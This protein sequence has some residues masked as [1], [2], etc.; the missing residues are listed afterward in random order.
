MITIFTARWVLPISASPIAQGAVAIQATHIIAVGTR[1]ELCR[2]FPDALLRDLGEA[3]LL[4]GFVN[5]HSH[6]ELTVYRGRLEHAEFQ[7]WISELVRLKQER[8]SIDDLRVSARLG[9]L[10]AIKAG[11]TT[12]ADTMEADA[13]LPALIESGQRGVVFQ[14]CFGPSVAQA[15]DILN[16]LR[17][18]LDAHAARLARAEAGASSRLRI[19]I[20]PHAPYSVSSRL[21]ELA[22]QFAIDHHF[23]LALH[24]AESC[25]EVALLT[26]GRGAFGAFLQRREIEFNAPACSTIKYFAQLGV[27]AA[28][29]LLI[30]CVTVD[31]ADIALLAQHRARV[32][33]CPKSN[34]KL[35]HGVAPFIAMRQAGLRIGLGTDSVGSNNSGD[36]LEEAR[37]GALLQRAVNKDARLC[38]PDEMLR[39]LTIDGARALGWESEIGSLEVGKQADLIAISL[40]GAHNTPH[41]DPAAAILFSC[42]ARDV[43]LTIVAGRTLYDGQSVTLLDEREL[44]QQARA[45]QAKLGDTLL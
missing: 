19:G 26:D 28:A 23:D 15:V 24:A 9:C 11:V 21:Y 6:L 31:E 41:Y 22:T 2:Q 5:V 43:I 35:G 36:L 42:S 39:L 25:D 34:A 27:L 44:L 45:I 18:K 37:F 7:P 13:V 17:A 8:L 20:S 3:A 10:E 29:P 16:I 40:D 30:H 4:P 14:E 38:T 33:H 32:A 12:V 1:A